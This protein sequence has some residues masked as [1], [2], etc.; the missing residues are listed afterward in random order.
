[1]DT[2]I[3]FTCCICRGIVKRD[4]PDGFSLQVTKFGAN[5]PEVVWAHGPCLRKVIPILEIEIPS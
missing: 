2:T 3:Q 5:S 4:E 1:M